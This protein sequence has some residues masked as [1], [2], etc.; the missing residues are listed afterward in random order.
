MLGGLLVM[1]RWQSRKKDLSHSP[2]K[3]AKRAN[4]KHLFAIF[5]VESSGPRRMM[6]NI[7]RFVDD[8]SAPFSCSESGTGPKPGM[9]IQLTEV[10]ELSLGVGGSLK[11]NRHSGLSNP[12]KDKK[13]SL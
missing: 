5:R 6:E 3:A 8:A 9:V 7:G 11:Q 10:K 4:L 13:S 1:T 12:F 2:L